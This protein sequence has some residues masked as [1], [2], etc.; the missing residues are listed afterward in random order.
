MCVTIVHSLQKVVAKFFI[1]QVFSSLQISVVE[2]G[3]QLVTVT[4]RVV[5]GEYD[6]IWG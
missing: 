1:Q 3:N 2:W 6:Y 4:M 5:G